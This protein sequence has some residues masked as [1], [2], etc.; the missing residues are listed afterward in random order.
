MEPREFSTEDR[1]QF[2]SLSDMKRAVQDAADELKEV[3]GYS[4]GTARLMNA[5]WAR[6]LLMSPQDRLVAI[7][8]AL[9]A[10]DKVR[11][12]RPRYKFK[13]VHKGDAEIDKLRS[14][15]GGIDGLRVGDNAPVDS[16]RT[17]DNNAIV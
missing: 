6:Y 2:V 3:L 9:E 13:F 12:T 16:S 7:A 10:L 4:V 8:P 14:I 17:R 15:A 1:I 11:K 5:L